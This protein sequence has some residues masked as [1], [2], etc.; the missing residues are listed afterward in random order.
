M[1]RRLSF[2]ALALLASSL[3]QC[4]A[5][6]DLSEVDPALFD[7]QPVYQDDIAPLLRE[8]CVPCHSRLG[9]RRGGVELDTYQAAYSGR[10]HNACVALS[11][12]VIDRFGDALTRQYGNTTTPC[13]GWNP[14]SM[15]SGARSRMTIAEQVLFARWV[16]TGAP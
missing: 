9:L 16:E 5:P 4:K 6:S 10:V 15:P 3:T 12:E 13:D 8:Y 2:A 1:E 11:P 14:L 7:Y